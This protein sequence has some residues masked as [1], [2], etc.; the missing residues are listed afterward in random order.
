MGEISPL[1]FA[2]I[3]IL[4]LLWKLILIRFDLMIKDEDAKLKSAKMRGEELI[5]KHLQEVKFQLS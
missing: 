3:Y 1:N 4:D 5:R 2:P